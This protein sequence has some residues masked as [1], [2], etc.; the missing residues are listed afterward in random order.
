METQIS[1][2]PVVI[3]TYKRLEHIKQTI[4]SL[5]ANLYADLTDVYVFS[6]AA[7]TVEDEEEV[8]AVRKYLKVIDGFKQITIIAREHNWGLAN[9]I[10]DGVTTIVNRYGKIIVLEDDLVSSKYFLQFMNEALNI[11]QTETRVMQ[12]SGYSHK[13]NQEGLRDTFF[14]RLAYPWGWATWADRWQYF[15]RNSDRLIEEFSATDIYNFT[16]EG[17]N[18][19]FWRQVLANHASI[20]H[21]WWVF[22]YAAIFQRG[23]LALYPKVSCIKNIGCDGTGVHCGDSDWFAVDLAEDP[24]CL[25]NIP[26]EENKLVLERYKLFYNQMIIE[27]EEK[28]L[29][30]AFNIRQA[31]NE[32]IS[33]CNSRENMKIVFFGTG[34][35]SKKLFERFPYHVDYFIDNNHQKWGEKFEEK[36]VYS[37]QKILEEDINNLIII[38]ASQYTVDISRQLHKM[39][40]LENLHFWNGLLIY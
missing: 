6:D 11:Y 8:N 38:L 20:M 19:D 12:V 2:A 28:Q 34:S 25:P 39:G 29:L 23:G 36:M 14:S 31:F 5:K 35:A 30:N 10:I 3:F 15:Q 18:N 22:F 32:L 33:K 16:L 9:N 40:F 4:E 21:T 37:P 1:L 24:I 26:I 27:Q 17:T 7:K 13:I